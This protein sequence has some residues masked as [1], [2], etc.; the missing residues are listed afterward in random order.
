MRRDCRTEVISGNAFSRVHRGNAA[1]YRSVFAELSHCV[2]EKGASGEEGLVRREEGLVVAG[3][4]EK[5][6][7][8]GFEVACQ[9]RSV[10]A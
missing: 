4:D 9:S 10:E 2:Y 8:G 6:D 7:D 5:L 1:V 3:S